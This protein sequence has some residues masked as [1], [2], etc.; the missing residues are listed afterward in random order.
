MLNNCAKV[1]IYNA[2]NSSPLPY[3]NGGGT[4]QKVHLLHFLNTDV[5]NLTTA[6]Y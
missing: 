3:L 4:L 2:H 6:G 1:P 5:V